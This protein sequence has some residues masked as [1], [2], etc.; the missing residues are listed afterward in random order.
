MTKRIS[1]WMACVAGFA[2]G[3]FAADPDAGQDPRAMIEKWVETRRLTAQERQDWRVGR[4]VLRERID[5]VRREIAALQEKTAQA[6]NEVTDVEKKLAAMTAEGERLKSAASGMQ[7]T[8]AQLE[9]GMRGL[10][11]RTPDPVRERIKPLSARLPKDSEATKI[12]APERLQVVLGI[13]NE[14][15]KANSE[16]N[17]AME[18]RSMPD[19]RSTEVRAVYVGLA[20]AYYVSAK[21]DAGIG[22]PG[23]AGW[24]WQPDN[25]LAPT[26]SDVIQIMQNKASPRF[27]P[28]PVKIK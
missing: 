5:L 7:T 16:I 15:T 19:G 25:T 26:V 22:R 1:I 3:A 24:D 23:D 14:L 17:L 8:V 27:V 28:L 4:E 11:I 12:T 6:T 20:Q 13:L 2:L 9:T 21:G 10:L 18:I